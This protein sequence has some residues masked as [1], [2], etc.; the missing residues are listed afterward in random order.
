VSTLPAASRDR[1]SDLSSGQ[2]TG[3]ERAQVASAATPGSHGQIV[4]L[5]LLIGAIV[6]L[7]LILVAL[8]VLGLY[9]NARISQRD[10]KLPWH[11]RY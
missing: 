8:V 7:F 1:Q 2:S 10:H 11:R 3:I 6:I 9:H 4:Q 5:T